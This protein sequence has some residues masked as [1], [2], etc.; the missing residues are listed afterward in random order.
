MSTSGRIRT[1]SRCQWSGAKRDRDGKFSEC[2][3]AD[4]KE[5]SF[6][7]TEMAFAICSPFSLME[8]VTH[9]ALP[10][11]SRGRRCPLTSGSSLVCPTCL[12]TGLPSKP[13]K[14]QLEVV[15][16]LLKPEAT[17]KKLRP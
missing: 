15:G 5:N 13:Q 1:V 12:S 6:D 2:A 8:T 17:Q 9:T 3:T 4:R 7:Y 16:P 11:K 14:R 10:F